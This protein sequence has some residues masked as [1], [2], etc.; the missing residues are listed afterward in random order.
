M[1]K[2]MTGFGKLSKTYENFDVFIEIKSVN[3]K[4]FD[5]N[6]KLPKIVSPLEITLR[7][8]LQEILSRGKID[9]RIE[10]AMRAAVKTPKLNEE[11]VKTYKNIFTRIAE[12][13]G[14]EDKP[15]LDHFLRITDIMDYEFN[16]NMEKEVE[17]SVSEA[18]TECASMLD[19]MRV[20]E[21]SALEKDI[22]SRLN[23]IYDYV[24]LIEKIKGD[25]FNI[26]KEKFIK[27]MEEMGV[28]GDY[29]DRIVQEASIMGE[30]ADISEEITRL[31]CHIEQFKKIIENE[32]PAGK[33]LDF[34]SQEI[35]REL[36]TI[37]SKSSKLEIISAVIEA[38]AESDR[39][40]EQVQN[41]V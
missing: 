28:S 14:M 11:A 10:I 22:K 33:K 26:W 39:I 2:S 9:V 38:K 23:V 29:E 41:I 18:V 35:H 13:S 12:L 17:K 24:T 40:R 19:K 30:K 16:G 36:N 37:S 1:V 20:K 31:K 32:Y 6:F 27:R 3:S 15:K 5:I 8:P 34:L 25:I 7:Q 4:Y 21:G